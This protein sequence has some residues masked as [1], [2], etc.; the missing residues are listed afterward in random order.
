MQ[1][2]Q[3]TILTGILFFTI[4]SF[5][6]PV[7]SL[8]VNTSI[9]Y[10]PWY[11]N[12]PNDGQWIK[13]TQ[14]NHKPPDD[15]ASNYYPVIGPY[16]SRNFTL[17]NLHMD[18]LRSANIGIIIISWWGRG[19]F[20]DLFLK[21]LLDT[22]GNNGIKVAIHIE[23]YE[24]RTIDTIKADIQ[25]IISNYGNYDALLKVARPTKWG[26]STLPRP[27]FYAYR[28][29]IIDDKDW[30]E[31]LDGLR[32]TLWD[33]LLIAQT[34]TYLSIDTAH[35]DGIYTYDVYAINGSIFQQMSDECKKRNV[36]F[37]ASVG[38][39]FIDIRA[40][41]G[42]NRTKSRE[43]GQ[44]YDFMWQEALDA[45]AEWVSITSFNEWL[46]GTNIEP[47]TVKSTSTYDY[48]NFEGAYGKTGVEA[49]TAYLNRTTYWI[50]RFEG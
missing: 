25:Y 17:M 40:V 42:S 11:G 8:S 48:M 43:N 12:P 21:D 31:M 23:P 16:G 39:G 45:K 29:V 37:S 30:A 5:I 34:F 3:L 13:W 27:V 24:T 49:Q 18:W 28:S 26:N 20:G 2:T 35:F 50:K 38:P 33:V 36:I 44:T 9:F 47:A 22:A 19:S 32:G 6:C 15:I 7:S 14:N 4:N 46:E 41:N 1:T 10:Y